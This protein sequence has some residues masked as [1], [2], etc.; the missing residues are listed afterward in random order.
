MGVAAWNTQSCVAH[1]TSL[2]DWLWHPLNY[3][4]NET[5]GS[6]KVLHMMLLWFF[7]CAIEAVQQFHKE[8]CQPWCFVSSHRWIFMAINITQINTWQKSQ[9]FNSRQMSDV[10]T[11]TLANQMRLFRHFLSDIINGFFFEAVIRGAHSS[12]QTEFS[13]CCWFLLLPT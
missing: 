6:F 9:K 11:L 5:G 2:A 1:W 4:G 10:P 13:A 3:D 8:A 12:L 7:A